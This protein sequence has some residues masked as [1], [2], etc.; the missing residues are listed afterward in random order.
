MKK[1]L[2]RVVDSC[3][4]CSRT[5]ELRQARKVS[6][7]TLNRSFTDVVCID[8]FH[9]GDRRLCHIM[10]S[11]TR[12]SVV[13]VAPDTS[14]DSAM[15]ALESHWIS[16]F[17]VPKAVLFDQAFANEKFLSYLELHGIEPR[18][19]PSRRHNKNVLEPKHRV[20]RDV[21]LR[22]RSGDSKQ[23]GSQMTCMVTMFALRM[24]L[25]KYSRGLLK[26]A[27][28]R[29]LFQRICRKLEKLSSPKEN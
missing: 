4:R 27:R 18:S 23:F 26:L 13:C 7:R 16:Q 25:P 29:N 10:C 2:N 3:E 19:I 5:H 6:L 11:S 22:L 1:Y 15:N 17:W 24:N 9:L 12:Y 28:S 8:H 14:M 20:I 21:F